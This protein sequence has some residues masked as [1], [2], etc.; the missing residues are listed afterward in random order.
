MQPNCRF[1]ARILHRIGLFRTGLHFLLEASE[2]LP[3]PPTTTS[4]RIP[5]TNPAL[6]IAAFGGRPR[7]TAAVAAAGLDTRDPFMASCA[8][9]LQR[10][11]ATCAIQRDFDRVVGATLSTLA[12]GDAASREVRSPGSERAFAPAEAA[13]RRA[14]LLGDRVDPAVD[15]VLSGQAIVRLYLLRMLLEVVSRPVAVA[16]QGEM[17]ASEGLYVAGVGSPCAME[18]QRIVEASSPG[19]V[20]GPAVGGGRRARTR[21]ERWVGG[22]PP[23][24]DV[25]ED[26]GGLPSPLYVGRLKVFKAVSSRALRPDW[27][28]SLLETCREEVRSVRIRSVGLFKSCAFRTLGNSVPCQVALLT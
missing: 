26:G 25:A 19:E 7:P 23:V 21:L 3:P 8:L 18:A 28:I 24:V 9:L 16:S 17:D 12:D 4:G 1:N 5:A 10:V 27:F 13:L 15:R 14:G 11:L 20:V 22:V 6:K 2:P